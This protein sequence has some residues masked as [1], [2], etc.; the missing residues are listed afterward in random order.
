MMHAY[1]AA[2]WNSST[3]TL[4]HP[5]QPLLDIGYIVLMLPSVVFCLKSVP[6]CW[7][8]FGV[9]GQDQLMIGKRQGHDAA[10][11]LANHV[12]CS[13]ATTQ[14]FWRYEINQSHADNEVRLS[15][16]LS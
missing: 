9:P 1:T 5:S 10:A 14:T 15:Y 2:Q 4:V 12:W 16:R 3:G 8:F 13:R 7:L 6:L 11:V